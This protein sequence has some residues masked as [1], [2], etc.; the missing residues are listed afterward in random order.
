MTDKIKA[1]FS[2]AWLVIT[3][4]LGAAVGIL[5]YYINGKHKEINALKSQIDLADTQKK[6]DLI[7]ADINAK[8]ANQDLLQKHVDEL[9]KS[10]VLLQD[11]RKQIPAQEQDKTP[12]QVEDYWKKN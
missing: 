8:L 12:D 6:A 3:L 10:L 1:F 11:Q 2:N 7:E 9:N 5:L 4:V